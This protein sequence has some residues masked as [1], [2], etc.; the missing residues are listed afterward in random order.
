MLLLLL[1]CNNIHPNP[2]LQLKVQLLD[3]CIQNASARL[4][5]LNFR[6]DGFFSSDLDM[7]QGQKNESVTCS[8][9]TEHF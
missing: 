5:G 2:L 8:V 9:Q 1:W 7:I 3:A 6:D 4:S